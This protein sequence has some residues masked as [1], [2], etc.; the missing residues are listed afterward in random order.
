M[1]DLNEYT[2]SKW[3]LTYDQKLLISA[4]N[5]FF[6]S[7]QRCFLLK[8]YAGTGKTFLTK[9]IAD[10]LIEE[11]Q[12]PVLMAPTGRASRILET[13][14]KHKSTTI[15]KGIYNLDEV[16]EIKISK[17]GKE[18]Y[19][20]KYNLRHIE[21]NIRNIYLIDEASMISDKYSEDDF[22]IFGSGR[23][24]ND[25]ITY[26][27]PNNSGRSDQIIFIGDPA[28]LP[29]V[30]D[31]ISGALS[32]EYLK[33]TFDIDSSE[34]ELTEVVRQQKESGILVNAT[35]IRNQLL[36]PRRNSFEL[37]TSF[38][39]TVKIEAENAVD[40]F[41]KEN[42]ELSLT[43]SIIINYS[44]KS[45]LDYNLRIREQLFPDKMQIQAG[46]VLMINQNNY[47]YEVE[48]LNGT[49]I[50]VI[51]VSPMP[52]LKIGMKSYDENGQDC[53]VT[54]KFRRIRIS[55]FVDDKE[56]ELICNILEN[57]LYSP[58]PTLTYAENI[59]LY[60]D[61]K[62]RNPH[63]KP[64][65]KPFSDALR[66]DPYF[67][68]LRVKYGYA[69]TCHK[70]QGG[71][72]ESAIVNLDVNQGIFSE[73][74]LR[75]T[76]TAI[77]R[78]SQKLY[79][80]N[81]PR[82]NQFSKLKY[83]HILLNNVQGRGK[84]I[85]EIR[86]TLPVDFKQIQTRFY[87]ENGENFKQEK[88]IEVL[89]IAH[90]ENMDVIG[91]NSHN[92]QEVYFFQSGDKKAGMIFWYNGDNKFTKTQI[93]NQHTNDLA[94]AA[95]LK[96]IFDQPLNVILTEITNPNKE[97]IIEQ[98][99]KTDLLF[100]EKHKAQQLLYTEINAIL[101]EKGIEIEKVEHL[102][103]QEIYRLK[104]GK[105][106]AAIQFYYDGLDRFTG[107][108]PLINQCN[109]NDLLNAVNEGIIELSKL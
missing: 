26:I 33:T 37:N 54:H 11:K 68:S 75:W 66:K 90:S 86:Y 62:I 87:L 57:F 7:N 95:D 101:G 96:S 24:L 39:D 41:L 30:T 45:A 99:W 80:F 22:F 34:Y 59:A 9:C 88:L 35:Y 74:F 48:L 77:T 46:D 1:T 12:N 102:Q 15:H 73:N 43:K 103:Y 69:I 47:N 2:N 83:N 65:T 92:N 98:D 67:N 49:L 13:K 8:G 81:I 20:F 16:D 97:A 55:V 100:D 60:L 44:N 32:K 107:A 17:D 10:Y 42:A 38:P 64:K 78:A 4:L 18:K 6:N 25:L 91:R 109:S 94:F 31:N 72:W 5:S 40:T 3:T 56:V 104:R 63:L 14:T 82:Q 19:K 70:A 28:Q 21:S 105:E 79:L 76:Y 71:E 52:E 85:R 36:N 29:P 93:S 53:K 58:N 84:D 50:K 27:S 106:V 61:F 51:E 108:Q 23:L 89:A